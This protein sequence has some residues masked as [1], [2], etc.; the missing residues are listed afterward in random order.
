MQRILAENSL[1]IERDRE[2]LVQ[3]DVDWNLPMEPASNEVPKHTI[4]NRPHCHACLS[5]LQASFTTI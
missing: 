3:F 1:P 5:Y 4:P 2:D